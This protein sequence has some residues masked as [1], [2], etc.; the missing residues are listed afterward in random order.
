MTLVKRHPELASGYIV[1]HKPSVEADRYTLK[2][3]QGDCFA[4]GL[5]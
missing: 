3:V 5:V 2:Q 4:R 1:P